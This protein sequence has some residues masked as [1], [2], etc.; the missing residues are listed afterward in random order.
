MFNKNCFE[1]LYICTGLRAERHHTSCQNFLRINFRQQS[2]QTWK[3]LQRR[4]LGGVK[5]G[6]ERQ[7]SDWVLESPAWEGVLASATQAR[8]ILLR[9]SPGTMSSL[10]TLGN[11]SKTLGTSGRSR[12]FQS[13]WRKVCRGRGLHWAHSLYKQLQA[14]GAEGWASFQA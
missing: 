9:G 10:K 1:I 5:G 4:N 14:P 7:T 11:L 2:T 8:I 12:Q 3:L 13:P 6:R